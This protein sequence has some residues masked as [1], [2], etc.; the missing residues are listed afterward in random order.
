MSLWTT[1]KNSLT[2]IDCCFNPKCPYCNTEL[3]F[4]LLKLHKFSINDGT[5]GKNSHAIDFEFVCPACG[6]WS[7]FGVAIDRAHYER[8]KE[9]FDEFIK[10]D[11]QQ[12]EKNG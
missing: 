7:P 8:V 10:N 4:S 2:E 3:E 12:M 9:R 5:D 11:K 1:N 6:F